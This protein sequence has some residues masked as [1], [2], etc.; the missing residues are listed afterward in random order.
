MFMQKLL[1]VVGMCVVAAAFASPDRRVGAQ[2]STQ[3]ALA[4][5]VIRGLRKQEKALRAIQISAHAKLISW[6]RRAHS[7]IPSEECSLGAIYASGGRCLINIKKLLTTAVNAP[8]PYNQTS[9]LVAYDGRVGTVYTRKSGLIGSRPAG[10]STGTISGHRPRW[11]SSLDTDSGWQFT[12]WGFA[13]R[14]LHDPSMEPLSELLVHPPPGGQVVYADAIDKRGRKFMEVSFGYIDQHVI[15]LDPRKGFAIVR[16]ETF[17][18]APILPNQNGIAKPVILRDGKASTKWQ[19][20]AT[21][22]QVVH[23]NGFWNPEPGVYFP[24][25]VISETFLPRVRAAGPANKLVVTI[26]KVV[27]F[28]NASLAHPPF[29]IRFPR[30]ATVTDEATGQVIRVGGTPRQQMKRID[31]AVAAAR[32]EVATQPARKGGGK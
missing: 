25:Q 26:A 6:N 20:A 29:I 13:P 12:I 9:F 15:R 27:P 19:W 18:A 30:G 8:A 1:A 31:E 23:V 5:R 22:T 14:I 11:A 16:D 24:K 32:N 28:K 21:P 4:G 7:M 10:V 2:S 3:P 17:V